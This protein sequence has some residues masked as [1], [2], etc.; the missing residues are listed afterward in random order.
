MTYAS[1][2]ELAALTGSTLPTTTLTAIL[3]EADRQIKSRL[4]LS[5]VSAPASDDKLKSAALS[6][7]R[8]GLL[9]WGS[10]EKLDNVTITELREDAHAAIDSYALS[11]ASDR[12]RFSIRK[13][14]A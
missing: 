6:L 2:A 11:S 14:N 13:V 5:E 8:A 7:G 1:T 9:Q 4:A 3:D 10:P 12:Y